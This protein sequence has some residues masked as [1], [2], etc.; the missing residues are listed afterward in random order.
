MKTKTILVGMM[1]VIGGVAAGLGLSMFFNDRSY[2]L[3]ERKNMEKQ[4]ALC[5]QFKEEGAEESLL[6]AAYDAFEKDADTVRVSRRTMNQ[7]WLLTTPGLA[8]LFGGV[9][10]LIKQKN[11]EGQ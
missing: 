4:Y 1:C 5:Q 6:R 9:L 7:S 11:Q 10:L 8:C 3:V 2:Y